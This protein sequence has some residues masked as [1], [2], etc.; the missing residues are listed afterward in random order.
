MAGI[1]ICE[2]PNDLK[3]MQCTGLDDVTT[4]GDGIQCIQSSCGRPLFPHIGVSYAGSSDPFDPDAATSTSSPLTILMILYSLVPYIL[5]MYFIA[6]FLALGNVVPLTRLGMIVFTSLV[7]DALLKN[8]VK[9]SR[10][11]GSCLYFHSYGMPR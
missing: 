6:H 11:T 3:L 8:I 4:C 9:Q 7:N 1:F 10:P 2:Q 5:L